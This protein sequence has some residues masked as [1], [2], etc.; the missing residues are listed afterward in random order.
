MV[1]I[2]ATGALPV[3]C[4]PTRIPR[5]AITAAAA[6]EIGAGRCRAVVVDV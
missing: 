5:L 1:V 3:P 4:L 6:S 2:V